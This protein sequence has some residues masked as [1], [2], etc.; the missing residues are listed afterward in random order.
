MPNPWNQQVSTKTQPETDKAKECTT[1]AGEKECVD[2][3]VAENQRVQD[4]VDKAFALQKR[5]Y[6]EEDTGILKEVQELLMG[7][8]VVRELLATF[9]RSEG[10]RI[11]GERGVAKLLK[12]TRNG[13]YFR[14]DM[15]KLE[16]VDFRRKNARLWGLINKSPLLKN[17]IERVQKLS[18]K[19]AR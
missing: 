15:V 5:A 11:G 13:V 8:L 18:E 2:M 3:V 17:L 19:P 7:I 6:D 1:T 4:V 14:L 10:R 9:E 12:L 16:P